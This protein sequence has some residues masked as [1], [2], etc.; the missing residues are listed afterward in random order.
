ELLDS[1]ENAP[2]KEQMQTEY[3]KKKKELE[4]VDPWHLGVLFD[5]SDA[6]TYYE[7]ITPQLDYE[8]RGDNSGEDL[9]TCE[10]QKEK[11]NDND[12]DKHN[13]HG[14]NQ[15][16]NTANANNNKGQ[17][18]PLVMFGELVFKC[19]YKDFPYPTWEC[20]DKLQRFDVFKNYIYAQ[21]N[22]KLSDYPRSTP[23][24]S[25]KLIAALQTHYPHEVQEILTN[26]S[27]FGPPQVRSQL[28]FMFYRN[29]D[30]W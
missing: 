7:Y 9:M 13:H 1:L 14:N 10:E 16:K 23:L 22:W 21:K 27:K 8:V 12:K 5:A 18:E 24:Q 26:M 20:W 2:D 15:N 3:E 4:K 11:D 28:R 25:L 6:Q 29:I 17:G 30:K 19:K